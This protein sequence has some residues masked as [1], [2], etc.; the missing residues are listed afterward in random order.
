MILAKSSPPMS[1]QQH[2][3][4][5]E[6][7][8]N[9]LSKW[10][11]NNALQS[12]GCIDENKIEKAKKIL[13]IS[14][15]LHDIGKSNNHFQ[16]L[17][18]GKKIVQAVRHEVLSSLLLLDYSFI[19]EKLNISDEDIDII[20]AIII[21]HHRKWEYEIDRTCADQKIKILMDNLDFKKCLNLVNYNNSKISLNN[22]DIDRS[23]IRKDPIEK[24]K[25]N[26]RDKDL[27]W[28]NEAKERK[29]FV[30]M[31]QISLM[32]SDM[33]ASSADVNIRLF[34]W[35]E[36]SLNQTCDSES[37]DFL[38]KKRLQNNS[39]LDFQKE[40]ENSNSRITLVKA[41]CGSGKTAGAYLWAKQKAVDK[42]LFFCYPTTGTA[43]EGYKDYLVDVELKTSLK[44]S[45]SDIDFKHILSEEKDETWIPS[46]T[47]AE[48]DKQIISC[49]ADSVLGILQNNLSSIC[50][51]P[52]ITQGAFVF[53][54]IHSYDDNLFKNLLKFIEVMKDVPILLMTASLPEH[55]EN[56]LKKIT[57][58]INIIKGP[59]KLETIKRYSYNNNNNFEKELGN[60]K[61]LWICNTVNSCINVANKYK[62][63]N[64]YI[65]H[66]RYKY[67]DRINRH[68]DVISA[69][70]QDKPC[71]VVTTQVAEMS[72]DLDADILISEIAPIP[73]M[74][75]RLGRLNRRASKDVCNFYII[76]PKN[77]LPYKKEEIEETKE[78][79][80][81]IEDKDLSQKD[82]ILNWHQKTIYNNQPIGFVWNKLF[83][84]RPRPLRKGFHSIPILLEEDVD[85][86]VNRKRDIKELL[87]QMPKKEFDS[88]DKVKYAF[89]PPRELIEYDEKMGARWV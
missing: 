2:L 55:R 42:K 49:T 3:E 18:Q 58:N 15:L 74:I 20:S 8:A 25:K 17:V 57:N 38:V 60:K 35:I 31:M 86:V 72:L 75:Q 47:F 51:W 48:W 11:I 44:H 66:S 19:K 33:L 88:W 40:I 85:D 14:A 7:C 27:N 77:C 65:Y 68:N 28:R 81:D 21:S 6:Q 61:V 78:W 63:F 56:E 23:I 37:L 26:V 67:I 89:V 45:R 10:C 43:T 69:F 82:L 62:E 52:C 36:K 22:I 4:E 13:K 32:V 41:G 12:F 54:E 1:L 76:E 16:N 73:S 70:K 71:F 59:E 79:L 50:L 29:S 39:P 84:C 34:D 9:F 30:S 83:E 64:P 24:F 46:N 53:D 80:I 5:V 87:I